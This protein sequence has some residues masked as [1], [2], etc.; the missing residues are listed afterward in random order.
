MIFDRLKTFSSQCKIGVEEMIHNIIIWENLDDIYLTK[1]DFL[2]NTDSN[3]E[4]FEVVRKSNEWLQVKLILDNEFHNITGSESNSFYWLGIK[5][6][7]PGL[8]YWD[9]YSYSGQY[10]I[11]KEIDILNDHNFMNIVYKML[12][13]EEYRIGNYVCNDIINIKSSLL[14][15]DNIKWLIEELNNHS[16]RNHQDSFSD[17][18]EGSIDEYIDKVV[19]TFYN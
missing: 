11:Y 12:V 3:E 19:N 8:I 5:D 15:K 9:H 18:F 2:E 6:K 14:N 1:K 7:S 16:I 10:G 4:I 13:E 17:Y